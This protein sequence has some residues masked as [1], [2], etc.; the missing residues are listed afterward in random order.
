MKLDICLI[1]V[2]A[3]A[4]AATTVAREAPA[5]DMPQINLALLIH[6]KLPK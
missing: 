2:V 4:A 6:P 1:S 5:A 3:L